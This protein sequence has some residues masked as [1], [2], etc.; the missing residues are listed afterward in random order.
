LLEWPFK[1]VF[2]WIIIFESQHLSEEKKRA[3][4]EL[5]IKHNYIVFDLAFESAKHTV[6]N[7]AAV[8]RVLPAVA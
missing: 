7:T 3:A 8:A 4:K 2:P 1:Q 5:L 6:R